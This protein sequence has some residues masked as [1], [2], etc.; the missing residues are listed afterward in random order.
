[1]DY[2]FAFDVSNEAVVSG[3]L[4]S[5]C[6][7]LKSILYGSLD[8]SGAIPTPPAFPPSLRIAIITFDTTLHFYDM[9]VGFHTS[10]STISQLNRP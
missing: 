9:A 1:M 2:V 3:F 6:D 8:A 5:T 10:L 7:A 4:Q